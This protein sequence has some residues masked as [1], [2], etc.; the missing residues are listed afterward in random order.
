[1]RKSDK[2]R[3]AAEAGGISSPPPAAGA[4]DGSGM[5]QRGGSGMDQRQRPRAEAAARLMAAAET[6]SAGGRD[7]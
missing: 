3:E 2:R 1:M 5:D 6:I 7:G 4:S